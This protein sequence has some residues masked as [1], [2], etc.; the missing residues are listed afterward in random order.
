MNQVG[1]LLVLSDT[2]THAWGASDNGPCAI[3]LEPRGPQVN[4][5]AEARAR[6]G[7]GTGARVPTVFGTPH[8][9][10][11]ALSRNRST[12]ALDHDKQ[13]AYLLHPHLLLPCVKR[14]PNRDPVSA[15]PEEAPHTMLCSHSPVPPSP[16]LTA[17]RDYPHPDLLSAIP[18]LWSTRR[19]QS[20]RA[21]LTLFASHQNRAHCADRHH[22]S[23]FGKDEDE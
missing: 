9:K 7:T 22:A 16:S 4:G 6:T 21:A 17:D 15:F 2:A 5:A 10:G 23:L 3:A 1:N 8:Q 18:S 14:L 20:A 11:S 13:Y 12:A 19:A